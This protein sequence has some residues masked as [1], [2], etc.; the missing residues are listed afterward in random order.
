[1][2]AAKIVCDPMTKYDR[3][4]G[5]D[6]DPECLGLGPHTKRC[7]QECVLWRKCLKLKEGGEEA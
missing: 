4:H 1:M 5:R 2:R 6:K 7:Y 3:D